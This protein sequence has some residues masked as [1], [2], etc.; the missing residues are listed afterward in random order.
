MRVGVISSGSPD[1]L[2]DIVT[3]GLIRLLGRDKVCLDYNVRSGWGGNYAHLLQGFVGPES[4]DIHDANVLVASSRSIPKMKAWAKKTG[5]CRP[6]AFLDG[7]DS[8]PLITHAGSEV[9]V[10]FKR[11]YIKGR[12]YPGNVKPLPF[13]AIPEALIDG[14]EVNNSVFYAGHDTHPFRKEIG[15]AL[16]SMGIP[17]AP[18]L[19]KAS[20]NKALMSSLVGVAVRGN[21]WD[22]Y[23]YWEIPYFGAALLSQRLGIVIPGDYEEGKE[24]LF[25]DSVSDFKVK[26]K[27]LM[28]DL[29]KT[30]EMARAGRAACTARHLSIHRAKTVLEA[31][32]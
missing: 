13:A 8:E 25:Y 23:R 20:Y 7:E 6:I 24:A 5:Y 18:K 2:V 14:I 10:Y 11:E 15:A 29:D 22:T 21:G 12:T 4:F 28:R 30:M 9:K 27:T 3:D 31:L 19:D 1:Y 17:P 16:A 32:S 26:L